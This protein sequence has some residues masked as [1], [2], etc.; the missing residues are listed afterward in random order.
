MFERLLDFLKDLPG[1]ALRASTDK[2]SQDNLRVAIAALLFHVMEADGETREVERERLASTLGQ[3]FR[4]KK[5]EVKRLI[6]AAEAADAE[7]IDLANFARVVRRHL[8]HRARVEFV[9]L[10]W[11][12]V[13]ADGEVREI[14]AD[15][16]WRVAGLMELT[17]DELNEIEQRV[18]QLHA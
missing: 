7:A 10:M 3:Y 16:M 9:M 4:L 11:D 18:A 12:L 14:E 2:D 13:C 17:D 1:A 15:V 5:D 6:K 8:D